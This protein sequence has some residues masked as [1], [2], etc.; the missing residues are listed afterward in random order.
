MFLREQSQPAREA[1]WVSHQVTRISPA[2][3]TETLA[4]GNSSQQPGWRDIRAHAM[5]WRYRARVR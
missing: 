3:L 5:I 4:F 2:R 1:E